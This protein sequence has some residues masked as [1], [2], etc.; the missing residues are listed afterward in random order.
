MGQWRQIDCPAGRLLVELRG[1]I[2]AG[3]GISAVRLVGTEGVPLVGARL[4]P[5][6]RLGAGVEIS[7]VRLVG[8]RLRPVARLGAGIKAGWA[9]HYL[10]PRKPPAAC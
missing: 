7:A 9:S 1:L 8:E 4:R 6:A 5:V 2:G 10:F 3:E